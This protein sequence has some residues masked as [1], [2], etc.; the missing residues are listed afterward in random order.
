MEFKINKI[1]GN[2]IGMML[3]NA[4]TSY[5]QIPGRHHSRF[6]YKSGEILLLIAVFMK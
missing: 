6:T 2:T 3:V 1:V 4:V 5:V